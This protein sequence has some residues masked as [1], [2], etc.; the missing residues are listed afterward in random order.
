MDLHIGE[1][2][3][4]VPDQRPARTFIVETSTG[5]RHGPRRLVVDVD[6]ENVAVRD[7]QGRVRWLERGGRPQ[8]GV[9]NQ[10]PSITDDESILLP[11]DSCEEARSMVSLDEFCEWVSPLRFE[12]SVQQGAIKFILEDDT[13][14]TVSVS[15]NDGT[16]VSAVFHDH[17]GER[18]RQIETRLLKRADM[19]GVFDL[20][21]K[22]VD[23]LE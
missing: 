2:W 16:I 21:V 15:P 12:G 3:L 17:A 6:G 4:T 22:T 1:A 19:S 10:L 20:V 9:G 8:V 7:V 18:L 23:G 14:V 13:R 11:S 5:F